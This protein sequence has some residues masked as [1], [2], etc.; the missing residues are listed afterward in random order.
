MTAAAV[1]LAAG[2][3]FGTSP[4]PVPAFLHEAYRLASGVQ[5]ARVAV[6]LARAWVYGGDADRAV[7]FAREAV[8]TAEA[9]DDATLLA[10]ALDAQLLVHWGPDQLAERLAI[11]RRLEDTVVHLTDVEARMSAHLWPLSTPLVH[12]N[13]PAHPRGLRSETSLAEEAGW[14]RV[15]FFAPSRRGMAA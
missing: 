12:H 11:T 8:T 10:D 13:L 9:A 1:G 2:Q 15:R 4:G 7:E 3:G 5:R 14:A 6:A